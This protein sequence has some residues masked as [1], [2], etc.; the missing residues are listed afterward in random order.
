V[1]SH[2]NNDEANEG[3]NASLSITPPTSAP[4][5]AVMVVGELAQFPVF[6]GRDVEG[7]SDMV[8]A[9]VIQQTR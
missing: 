5:L 7:N 2:E 4:V 8:D 6:V 1:L 9:D 3:G